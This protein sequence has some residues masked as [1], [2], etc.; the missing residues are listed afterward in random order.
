MQSV[1]FHIVSRKLIFILLAIVLFIAAGWFTRTQSQQVGANHCRWWPV[2]SY[3]WNQRFKVWARTSP[4]LSIGGLGSGSIIS[5]IATG[6]ECSTINPLINNTL[7]PPV[8]DESLGFLQYYHDSDPDCPYSAASCVLER[9]GRV[10]GND[11]RKIIIGKIKGF[12]WS[13]LLGSINFNESSFPEGESCF[14]LTG[15][16]RQARVIGIPKK[17]DPGKFSHHTIAGCAYVPNY[18]EWII[19]S[20]RR[21]DGTELLTGLYKPR[22]RWD[23]VVVKGEEIT[24]TEG[25]NVLASDPHIKLFNCGYSRNMGFWSL[26]PNESE[27]KGC[28]PP[29]SNDRHGRRV[30]YSYSTG[31]SP[32]GGKTNAYIRFFEDQ[33]AD[34]I[35]NATSDSAR[36]GQKVLYNI[37]CPQG[38]KEPILTITTEEG[39]ESKTTKR[40]APYEL[41]Y[42][43]VFSSGIAKIGIECK[44]VAGLFTG[45]KESVA[46]GVFVDAFF[47]PQF[48]VSPSVIVEGGFVDFSGVVS[49]WVGTE[50]KNGNDAS[51]TISDETPGRPSRTVKTFAASDLNNQIT[52]S[53]VALR[54]TIYELQCRYLNELGIQQRDGGGSVSSDTY[55]VTTQP[56]KAVVKVFPSHLDQKNVIAEDVCIPTLSTNALNTQNEK[57]IVS[58]PSTSTSCTASADKVSEI[59]VHAL[60][61]GGVASP[62]RSINPQ[63]LVQKNVY[64]K[65]ADAKDVKGVC[66]PTKTE[67]MKKKEVKDTYGKIYSE[68]GTGNEKEVKVIDNC[69]TDTISNID[70][71]RSSLTRTDNTLSGKVFVVEVVTNDGRR[72]EKVFISVP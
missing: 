52:G 67:P 46:A 38:Y 10:A 9:E 45:S 39:E 26:G 13:P 32:T 1:L 4:L 55:W 14:G 29:P 56:V 2:M 50:S 17:S 20:N 61:P 24:L 42:E 51:C 35:F 66:D 72:S 60:A 64:T 3:M 69:V 68:T 54:D 31:G 49:N 16:D 44:D 62:Y 21:P 34:I 57:V 28:L 11:E 36:I 43:Q 18:N 48:S 27:H 7:N 33:P 47:V 41:T 58:L 53:D 22:G 63:S 8:Q 37:Q 65:G 40:H 23:E 30:S 6:P 19:F 12:A 70:V 71:G 25:S 5:K 15:E 59:R